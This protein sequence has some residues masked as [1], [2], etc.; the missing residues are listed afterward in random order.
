MKIL[1][2]SMYSIHF[3]R[4]AEQLRDSDHEIYWIDVFDSN[5]YVKTIE[6][7][8]QTVGWRNRWDYPGR[9]LL[10]SKAP[11]LN[12]FLNRI[13]QRDLKSILEEKIKEIKPDIVHSFVLQSAAFSILPIMRKFP[14]IKWVYSAW[15]NDLFYRQ[16]FDND[17]KD[18]KETLP[19][20]DY[21]F[22]D[23]SRYYLLAKDLGF[24][25]KYLGTYPTGGGYN[26]VEYDS[27]ISSFEKKR[28]IIIKGYQGKLGR[29]NRVLEGLIR[30]KSELNEYTITVFG[31]NK[32]VYEFAKKIGL[33]KWD[34]FEIKYNLTQ[35][36]VLKLMGNARISV[37]NS[38]SD[39]LPNTL[40]ES[41][42]MNSF[43]IQSDP[44]GATSELIAHEK[45]GFLINNPEDCYEIGE[46]ISRAINDPVF[47]KK[48]IKHNTERIKPYLERN[49]IKN[50]V[51]KK[52]R[53]IEKQLIS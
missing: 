34:N 39:G 22:A 7:I 50:D 52:Y 9:Y 43:P 1:M 25:G 16:N 15:G 41:I 11:V 33:L 36:E 37:G 6:F 44:G 2:V 4:W 8:E 13:N 35:T 3:F 17:L 10:K 14:E 32:E 47:M 12:K 49:Y 29:C 19:K 27:F 48:A 18:I 28:R 26:L 24:S 46:L 53:L 21:M 5:T 51:V 20:F 30:I 40:L 31:A 38:I 42:I 23:C 45:N